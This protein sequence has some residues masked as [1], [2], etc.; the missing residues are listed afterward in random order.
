MTS[1]TKSVADHVPV[2]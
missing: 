2:P 1:P